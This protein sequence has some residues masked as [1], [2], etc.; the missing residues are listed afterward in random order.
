MTKAEILKT[1]LDSFALAGK[2]VTQ[3]TWQQWIDYYADLSLSI[4]DDNY[5]VRMLESI[6]QVYEDGTVTVKKEEV[7]RLTQTIRHK[8]LDLSV[9][10]SDEYVL[11]NLFRQ[12]DTNHNGTINADEL[13]MML[14]K[15]QLKISTRYLSALLKK[16]DRN[17]S[18]N[19]EFEDL[20]A[21]LT[22]NPYK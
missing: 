20:V 1:F 19:V 11:R 2:K 6:W 18:G 4:V 8:L 22:C 15:I 7:E 3:I 5:F 16:F 14:S 13:S 9:H 12:L 17:G 21:Y 10:Q